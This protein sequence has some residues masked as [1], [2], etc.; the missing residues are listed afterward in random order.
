MVVSSV[1][2][3]TRKGTTNILLTNKILQYIF[4]ITPNIDRL[5]ESWQG[6]FSAPM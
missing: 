1:L 6:N 5:K 2:Y 3:Y 4:L